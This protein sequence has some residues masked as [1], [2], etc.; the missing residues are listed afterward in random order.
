MYYFFI[1]S[2]RSETICGGEI[3]VENGEVYSPGYPEGYENSLTCQWTVSR[4]NSGISLPL[5]EK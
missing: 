2:V 5:N 4:D 3:T 1:L